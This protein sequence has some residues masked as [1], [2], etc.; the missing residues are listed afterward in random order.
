[1]EFEILLY[2]NLEIQEIKCQISPSND[3][4]LFDVASTLLENESQQWSG[5][6]AA[7]NVQRLFSEPTNGALSG[8]WRLERDRRQHRGR[9]PLSLIACFK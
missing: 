2:L 5:T 8:D 7:P 1:M 3:S 6:F 9:D 4:I